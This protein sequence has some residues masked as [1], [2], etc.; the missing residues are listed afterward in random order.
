MPS[1]GVLTP[2]ITL[3]TGAMRPTPLMPSKLISAQIVLA[4]VRCVLNGTVALLRAH[5][6]PKYRATAGPM[7]AAAT[8]ELLTDPGLERLEAE[9]EG[10]DLALAEHVAQRML[11]IDCGRL[12][13]CKQVHRPI[14]RD[15]GQAEGDAVGPLRER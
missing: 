5:R 7:T 8:V 14:L 6:R 10:G 9:V 11:R 13:V 12:D 1:V 15:A 3:T 4:L 2:S